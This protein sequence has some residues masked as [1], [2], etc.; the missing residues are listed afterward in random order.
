MILDLSKND[1]RFISTLL[2]YREETSNLEYL[3]F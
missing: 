2:L 3:N 1:Y